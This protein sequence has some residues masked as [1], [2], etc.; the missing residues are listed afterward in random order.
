LL[1]RSCS[2]SCQENFDI[3]RYLRDGGRTEFIL[4][5]FLFFD[6]WRFFLN[7]ITFCHHHHLVKEGLSHIA[8][9]SRFIAVN[10]CT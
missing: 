2:N 8:S 6:S 3:S 5:F 7:T 10:V 9:N 1:D 4:F